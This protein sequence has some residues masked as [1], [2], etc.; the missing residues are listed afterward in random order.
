MAHSFSGRWALTECSQCKC[1]L[2]CKA[3]A[4]QQPCDVERWALRAGHS[5][6]IPDCSVWQ[7]WRQPLSDFLTLLDSPQVLVVALAH[8][9]RG[10]WRV[11][12]N[13]SLV[14]FLSLGVYFVVENT[15][16]SSG[17]RSVAAW[18]T[19]TTLQW[20]QRMQAQESE[21]WHNHS[22]SVPRMVQIYWLELKIVGGYAQWDA[23]NPSIVFVWKVSLVINYDLPNSR[24]LY[25]HRIGRSG[26]YGRKVRGW[27]RCCYCQCCTL[28]P[29]FRN[30][31]D[32]I[33]QVILLA[34]PGSVSGVFS[35]LQSFCRIKTL[36]GN[37]STQ[38]KQGPHFCFL[39]N[40]WFLLQP[41]SWTWLIYWGA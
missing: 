30:E 7:L 9:F 8:C 37:T 39:Y 13:E 12:E 19:H 28:S 23:D 17:N 38:C 41:G 10:S 40:S 29:A 31:S 21:I 5:G 25:I 4:S 26:R 14:A 22:M 2:Y 6:R 16:T 34:T 15:K 18:A 35:L 3:I 1:H 36:F 33:L 32:F 11:T 27:H 20:I 24:E